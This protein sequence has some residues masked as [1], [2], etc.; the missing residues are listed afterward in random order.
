M[1]ALGEAE[2]VDQGFKARMTNIKRY[3]KNLTQLINSPSLTNKLISKY[4][5]QNA[6]RLRR[7]APAFLRSESATL[8]S[9]HGSYQPLSIIHHLWVIV[10]FPKC[11]SESI[12]ATVLMSAPFPIHSV[13]VPISGCTSPSGSSQSLLAAHRAWHTFHSLEAQSFLSDSHR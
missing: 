12:S 10:L 5:T 7:P 3:L 6:W 2:E 4:R 9:G 8:V 11:S 13:H 1:P